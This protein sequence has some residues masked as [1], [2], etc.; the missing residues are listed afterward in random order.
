MLVATR[1]LIC[2]TLIFPMSAVV[3]VTLS[4]FSSQPAD[5]E[6]PQQPASRLFEMRVYTTAPGKLDNLHERFREH[7]NYLFVKHGI[8]LIAYWVP[9]AKP[10]TLIYTLAYP[11]LEARERSWKAFKDDPEWQRVWAASKEKAGGPIVT[12]VEST[13]MTPTDY[14]PIR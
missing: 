4:M 14:S 6:A 10:D 12:K 7:T 8:S 1:R 2:S 3:I 9:Q 13:F 11:D 5:A